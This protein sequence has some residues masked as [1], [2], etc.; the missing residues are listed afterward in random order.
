MA[1]DEDALLL[2]REQALVG[3][4]RSEAPRRR[5]SRRPGTGRRVG[6]SPSRR[7]TR[8]SS[9]P[10]ARRRRC[11]RAG[12]PPR[13]GHVCPSSAISAVSRVRP[14]RVWTQ[15]SSSR[16]ADL[17]AEAASLAPALLRQADR[18]RRV[19]VDA[20]HE[21]QL[22]LA[23]AHEHEEAHR[24]KPTVPRATDPRRALLEWARG[25]PRRRAGRGHRPTHGRRSG[26]R[27]PPRRR[28]RDLRSRVVG[29]DPRLPAGQGPDAGALPA[30]RQG[31]HL[32]R[33][34]RQPHLGLVLERGGAG[35]D[36]A[37][38]AAAVRLRAADGGRPG[39]AVPGDRARAAEDR[40]RRLGRARGAAAR[41]RG[42]GRA[43][44]PGARGAA[45][46]GRR[47]RSRRR[48][49]GAGRRHASSSTSSRRTAT[50]SATRWSRS[51]RGG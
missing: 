24:A 5:G 28:A 47:A 27:R 31:A 35:Q 21:V 3:R 48:P 18:D 37:D 45:R 43:R 39:L 41:R 10:R 14:K 40:G 4:A 51:V 26:P 32:L 2:A 8:R 36:P 16:P 9:G 11:R 44:R 50:R 46:V 29:Q 15:R 30:A 38:R 25:D 34:G 1:D 7:G 12:P 6:A 42:A 13:A 17:V 33:G 20:A 19:A 22:G 23:V 49:P